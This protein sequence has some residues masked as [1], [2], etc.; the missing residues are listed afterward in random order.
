MKKEKKKEE[1]VSLSSLREVKGLSQKELANELNVSVGLIGLYE[2]G[3]RK[4]SFDRAMQ[5]ARYFDTPVE[6]IKFDS[7]TCV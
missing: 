4:P 1:T 2:T 6:R 5:I 3:R 7:R